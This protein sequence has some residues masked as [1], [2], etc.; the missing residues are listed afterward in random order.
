[1]K[2]TL[3]FSVLLLSGCAFLSNL[4]VNKQCYIDEEKCEQH[5]LDFNKDRAE[6][7][8]DG[9][10]YALYDMNGQA[11]LEELDA[12]IKDNTYHQKNIINL[13]KTETALTPNEMLQRYVTLIENKN[14][15]IKPKDYAKMLSKL[16]ENVEKGTARKA[17]SKDCNVYGLTAT[18]YINTNDV[19]TTFLGHFVKDD[20]AYA[21]VVTFDNPQAL[22]STYNFKSSGWNATKLAG[23]IINNICESK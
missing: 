1:M 5:L 16:R 8:T 17:N 10:Y 21:I 19:V 15:E 2:K 18:D 20:K 14:N 12:G 4:M 23:K 3:L 22:K 13:I 9:A 6:F 11:Y 7:K